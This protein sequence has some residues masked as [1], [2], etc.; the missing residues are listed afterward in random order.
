M[1]LTVDAL[2][3]CGITYMSMVHDSFAV[4]AGMVDELCFLLRQS[5]VEM[6]SV[7]RLQAFADEVVDPLP[8]DL[9]R[10]I[11]PLPPKGNLVLEQIEASEY[12]FA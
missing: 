11:P 7:D 9:R 3:Q 5:Y 4:H 2:L 10:Q 1:L 12:F 8:D 6:Y